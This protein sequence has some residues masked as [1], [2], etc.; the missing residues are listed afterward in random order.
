MYPRCLILLL[1]TALGCRSAP[2]DDGE[3]TATTGESASDTGEV[4]SG[5]TGDTGTPPTDEPPLV[6][7]ILHT[8]LGASALAA[9]GDFGG[10]A[11]LATLLDEL[12]DEAAQCGAGELCGSLAI[13]SGGNF[14]LGPEL[15]VGLQRADEVPPRPLAESLVID[16]M[17]FDAMGLRPEDLL[18]RTEV[19]GQYLDGFETSPPLLA[20]NVTL[21]SPPV[22]ASTVVPVAGRDIGIIGTLV[23]PV[24]HAPPDVDIADRVAARVEEE[25]AKLQEAG[26]DHVILLANG[27]AGYADDRRL[28]ANVEGV[29]VAISG[30]D[31]L[32]ATAGAELVPGDVPR[33]TYPV[34]VEDEAGVDVP[35]VAT[36]GGF[37][38]VGRLVVELDGRGRVLRVSP[39][40]DPVRVVGAAAAPDGVVE[41]PD[42]VKDVL[43]PLSAEVEALFDDPVV[44]SEVALDASGLVRLQE[45]NF[46]DLVADALLWEGRPASAAAH[47]VALQHGGGIR[48]NAELAPGDLSAFDLLT[49]VPEPAHLVVVPEVSAEEL[50][51]VLE[52]A[53]ADLGGDAF[54]QVAGL[55]IA[56]DPSQPPREVDPKTGAVL[57]PGA[58]VREV[59]VVGP[60]GE[61]TPLLVAGAPVA[62]A[63]EVDVVTL[64]VNVRG[65]Y[66]FDATDPARVVHLG[67]L[68]VRNLLAYVSDAGGLAGTIGAKAYPEGGLGRITWVD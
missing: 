19:L 62:D 42:L 51:E 10:A 3:D 20:A 6:L 15:L 12:R 37:E 50:Q 23:P 41:D 38:Y 45:T 44:T 60:K 21:A 64:D 35:L 2:D 36:G 57:E 52:H 34:L 17:G 18:L 7:T 61:R 48:L 31:V 39:D 28:V 16:A 54:A 47:V 63:P 9:G 30:D 29:D 40:S 27:G 68:Q 66:P 33:D 24:D 53:F 46:G 67:T 1:T 14:A 8:T 26:V 58:R 32:L 65:P 5:T 4:P 25:V 56:V 22:V 59:T 13:T 49:A 11:R 55:E 43:A